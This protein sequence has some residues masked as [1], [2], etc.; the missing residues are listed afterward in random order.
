MLYASTDFNHPFRYNCGITNAEKR[1]DK[2]YMEKKALRVMVCVAMAAASLLALSIAQPIAP[3]E[4]STPTATPCSEPR[5]EK[6][7]VFDR[8]AHEQPIVDVSSELMA[9]DAKSKGYDVS[10]EE[11]RGDAEYVESMA[12]RLDGIATDTGYAIAIDTST[13]RVGIFAADGSRY[14]LEMAFNADLGYIDEST[15]TTH[16]FTGAWH[17][18]HH[19]ETIPEGRRSSPASCRAGA[20][21]G[22]TTGRDSIAGMMAIPDTRVPDA[23]ACSINDARYIYDNMP[24]GTPVIVY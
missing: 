11:W 2:R 19:S 7:I 12:S 18:D 9:K 16:T 17:I 3:S 4:A 13:C 21:T 8:Q 22:R 20:M 10:N 1:L 14:T 5:G 23:R 6:A 24:D 15:G